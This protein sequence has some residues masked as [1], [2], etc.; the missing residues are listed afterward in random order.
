MRDIGLHEF[1]TPD[2]FVDL[3]NIVKSHAEKYSSWAEEIENVIDMAPRQLRQFME[4]LIKYQFML[5]QLSARIVKY[6]AK[7][8]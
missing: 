3:C 2:E 7:K 8:I 1:G 4:H 6:R 5:K